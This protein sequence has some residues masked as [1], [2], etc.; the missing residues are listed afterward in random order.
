MEENE[1]GNDKPLIHPPV[2]GIDIPEDEVTNTPPLVLPPAPLVNSPKTQKTTVKT[3]I[4][5]TKPRRQS[6]E[7][8]PR[9]PVSVS[10]LKEDSEKKT[11]QVISK[12]PNSNRPE[13]IGLPGERLYATRFIGNRGYVVTFRVTDPLY[14]LDLSDPTDPF[15]AGELKIDGYSDYLHPI[16]ENLLLG[17]GKDAKAAEFG[18]GRGAW[19]QGVKLSLIDISNPAKPSEVD[20]VII[21]KR[22][23]E[24][25]ALNNHHA[26]TGLK[27]GDNYRLAIPVQ[28]HDGKPQYDKTIRPSTYYSYTHT[29]LYRFEI[30]IDQQ[31]I[32][33]KDGI[34]VDQNGPTN[35][36]W[37]QRFEN[38]RSVFIN[39]NVYYMH[40]GE[41]WIQDWSG[42]SPVIGPK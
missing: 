14:I 13:A 29:G 23:T 22:G 40:D 27:V 30:D 11:L 8:K 42:A 19:Y 12:L 1:N 9:S 16:S 20:K 25:A 4:K 32:V 2:E 21:G 36:K 33:Q 7:K 10:I 39:D 5:V 38:D 41:F 37:E 3:S 28:L 26:L 18:D 31:H 35:N 24:S 6:R 15:I 17:I 34:L